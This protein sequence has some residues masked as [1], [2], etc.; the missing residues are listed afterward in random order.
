MLAAATFWARPALAAYDAPPHNLIRSST[1][2]A[3]VRAEFERAHLGG[4]TKN[5]TLIEDW[6]LS[7]G[8][9]TGS[10]RVHRLGRDYRETTTLGPLAYENGM[11]GGIRWQQNRNGI[12]FTYSGFHER[13]AISQGAWES[14]NERDVRLIGESVPLNAFV[15]EIDPPNGRRQWLFI[16]KH[17]G[18]TVRVDKLER[19]R[20]IVTTF[21][22]FK[23]FDGEL[24]PGHIRTVDSLGNER[25]QTLVSRSLDTTPDPA[26]VAI[27]PSR[28]T[29]VEFP[30]GYSAVRLP[31]RIVNGL[32]VV[33]VTLGGRPFDFLLDSGAAGIVIDPIVAE[34]LGLERYGER[35]GATIGP[36]PET[37]AIV[38]SMT[39]GMLRMHNVVSR[40]VS[41]P[42]RADDRTR[43]TGL[44]GFDFF[45]EIVVH[46]DA[47]R[48]IFEALHPTAFHPSSDLT[49]LPLGLDDKQPAIRI[50]VGPVAARV[51]LDTGANRTVLESAFAER[52]DPEDDS[53][54][55]PP[56]RFRGVAGTGTAEA[57]RVKD[58]DIAG[59]TI[60]ETLVDVSAA[61][62]GFEDIDGLI[63]TDLMR[64]YDLFFDYRTNTVFARHTGHASD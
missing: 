23:P 62:L 8:G 38:P 55:L 18:Q 10:F 32:L 14:N 1:T 28:R 43:V 17:N 49:A 22:D 5:A 33:R 47:E 61:D 13:D 30:P 26:D 64:D 11:H 12:T 54:A 16:D 50:K 35:I 46:I 63:G 60:P 9:Q 41:I 19:N 2:L 40:V 39:V 36:F 57:V 24:L 15:I 42:F 37:T 51:I 48:G 31:V 6:R 59:N 29:L 20:R 7:Q 34:S 58:I 53:A 44:L 21:D 52:L 4:R 27:V 45:A 56:A 3:R 25:E